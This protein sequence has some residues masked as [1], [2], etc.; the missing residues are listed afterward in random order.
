MVEGVDYGL[1]HDGFE[2]AEVEHHA[3]SRGALLLQGRALYGDEEFVGVAVYVVA[4]ALVG[5]QGV[6]HL[7]GEFFC[8]AEQHGF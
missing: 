2:F 1:V 4:F 3:V 8:K 7:K 5:G 6:G